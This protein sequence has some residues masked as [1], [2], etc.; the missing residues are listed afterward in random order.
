M[1]HSYIP[2][3]S[4]YFNERNYKDK[5][6]LIQEAISRFKTYYSRFDKRIATTKKKVNVNLKSALL[7]VSIIFNRKHYSQ[8]YVIENGTLQ[9][10]R[11]NY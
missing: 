8:C 1:K 3:I 10:Q 5:E 11:I 9:G 2:E 4:V 7:N 6:E